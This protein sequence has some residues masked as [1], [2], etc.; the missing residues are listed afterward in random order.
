MKKFSLIVGL[1]ICF[2]A[3]H[4][5]NSTKR[6]NQYLERYEYFDSS[7]NIIGYNKWNPYLEQ[8]E[9]TDIRTENSYNR[10]VWKHNHIYSLPCLWGYE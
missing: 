5:Q 4:S 8:W 2:T 3:L 7:G 10:K 1:F 9:Y 6:Y